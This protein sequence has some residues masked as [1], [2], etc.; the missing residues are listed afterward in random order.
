MRHIVILFLTLLCHCHASPQAADSLQPSQQKLIL[1][2]RT[3]DSLPYFIQAGLT[4]LSIP[5]CGVSDHGNYFIPHNK[6]SFSKNSLTLNGEKKQ[7]YILLKGYQMQV[8]W[9]YEQK[10]YKNTRECLFRELDIEIRN[11]FINE[12]LH[13]TRMG[14]N[15]IFFL[16]GDFSAAMKISTEGLIK[17]ERIHDYE[18]MAHYNNVLGC[19]MMKLKNFENAGKYF[20]EELRLGKLINSQNL[21]AHAYMNLADLSIAENKNKEAIS[22]INNALSIY[23]NRRESEFNTIEP[24][25][26]KITYAHNKLSEIYKAMD[27]TDSSL[28]YILLTIDY[29]ENNDGNNAYDKANYY[30]NAGDIYN[31]LQKPDSALIYLRKGL[32]IAD[33]I[34]HREYL[35]NAYEQLSIS[36]ALEKRF[37]SA[38][39]YQQKF[40][41]LKDSIQ[42]EN[43]ERDILQKE[44]DLKVEREKRI[45]ES[46]LSRQ[47]LWRN[48]IIGSLVFAILITIMLYNRRRIK[49]KMF[50]Q[51]QLNKQQAEMMNTVIATQ[52]KERKRI[53]EDLHDS[54]GSILS[55]AKL[56]LST[57][58]E[59]ISSNGNG[60]TK[61]FD[62]T[63][64]LIDEAVN[65]MRN[66][67]HNLLPASLLRLGLVAGLQNLFDKISAKSGLQIN[68]NTHGFK[69][70][71][72]ESTEVSIYRIILEAVNNVIKHAKAKNVTVQLMQYDNYINILV[73]DDGVGFFKDDQQVQGIGLNNIF[74]RVDH[75]KGKIDIDTKPKAGTVINIDIP[76]QKNIT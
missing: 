7:E 52:D 43:S 64:N 3:L 18:R 49:Q 48:I 69:E 51:Q 12:E 6:F 47:R 16:T 58:E 24:E 29:I 11:G 33:S 73:E 27:Q 31:R 17:A 32:K 66:I 14:L 65:E 60:Q 42:N 44:A 19:V 15:N 72:D 54:L 55:A 5:E 9:F 50:Y 68:F 30:V 35:R 26:N 25:F 4:F 34:E 75:M 63:M 38:Y 10:K 22:N 8:A 57:L 28:K 1:I 62:D 20:S 45:Q 76:Y 61:N 40:S 56:K 46:E 53:A 39:A 67:S 36:Y 59:N 74:S 23:K 41:K 2:T 13:S 21:M 71:L 70:R 37:D